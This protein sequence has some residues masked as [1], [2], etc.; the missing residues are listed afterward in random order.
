MGNAVLSLTHVGGE[1]HV[2]CFG[3]RARSIW[4]GFY[5]DPIP[6][7]I[8][9]M[10]VSTSVGAHHHTLDRR[11]YVPVGARKIWKV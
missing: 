2:L 10:T 4:A 7:N 6:A 8:A 9:H 1:S 5:R 3:L 11:P